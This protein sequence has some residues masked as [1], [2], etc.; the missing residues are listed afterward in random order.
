MKD[1]RR[2]RIA[3]RSAAWEARWTLRNSQS[4]NVWQRGLAFAVALPL[5]LAAMDFL[6]APRGSGR[7]A[8]LIALI[9]GVV[10]LAATEATSRVD[11]LR[12]TY[13]R[14]AFGRL[15][16]LS[17]RLLWRGPA[18]RCAYCH[19]DLLDEAT[20][21]CAGCQAVYHVDCRRDG[22]G[23]ACATPECSQARPG[24]G[25]DPKPYPPPAAQPPSIAAR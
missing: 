19:G 15:R 16:K 23:G 9:G 20:A 14:R 7:G 3:A 10:L 1:R 12:R 4:L 13:G 17:A 5:V 18:V 22:L 11:P 2:A 24:R 25:A 21:S 8:F 6:G